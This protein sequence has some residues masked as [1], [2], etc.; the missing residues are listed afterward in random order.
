MDRVIR[1]GQECGLPANL[2]RPITSRDETYTQIM[3]RGWIAKRGAFVQHCNTDV[4]NAS[5]LLM[6]RW[7]LCRRPTP[8]GP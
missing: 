6:P 3:K 5:L 8:Y 2:Q 1:I 7:A 4:L